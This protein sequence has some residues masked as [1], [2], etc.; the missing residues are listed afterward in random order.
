M[1]LQVEN[2]LD[3]VQGVQRDLGEL[4]F[5]DLAHDLQEFIALPR[6]MRKQ[7][8][9]FTVGLSIQRNVMYR[10]GGNAQLTSLHAVDD[11]HRRDVLA[12]VNVPW[13]HAKTHYTISRQEIHMNANPR[14]IVDLVKLGRTDA[15]SSA[16]ELEEE[17]FWGKPTSS[18]DDL[19]AWGLSYWCV[20]NTSTGFYGTNPAGFSDVGGLDTSA[21]AYSRYRNWTAQYTQVTKADLIEKMRQAYRDIQF[22]APVNVPQYGGRTNYEIFTN[23][24]VILGF[25]ALVEG[26]NENMGNDLGGKKAIFWGNPITLAPYLNADSSD[27]VYFIDWGKFEIYFLRGEFMVENKPKESPRS[28]TVIETW[29]DWS[30]NYVQPNRRSLAVISK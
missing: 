6:I 30:R 24:D 23:R 15:M 17:Q 14:K 18:S 3:A 27:P 1:A 21:T 2:I 13:R 26:Q 9:H 10:H 19:S 25:D 8:V 28:H 5:E 12:A 20:K 7:N 29:I 22:K 4:K 16:A 11:T